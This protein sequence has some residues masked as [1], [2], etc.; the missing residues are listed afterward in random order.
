MLVE[1]VELEFQQKISQLTIGCPYNEI[2][3]D[4]VKLLFRTGFTSVSSC[5]DSRE[6]LIFREIFPFMIV[7]DEPNIVFGSTEKDLTV[8]FG[9]TIRVFTPDHLNRLFAPVAAALIFFSVIKGKSS[10]V[11]IKNIRLPVSLEHL[12]SKAKVLVVGAGGLGSPAIEFLLREGLKSLV[13]IEPDVV[14]ISN[15]HRQTFYSSK[16]I[17][18][19]KAEVLKKILGKRDNLDLKIYRKAFDPDTLKNEQP[20]V[21]IACVDNYKTR[22]QINEICYKEGIPFVDAGVEGLS[23]YVVP[24]RPIDACYRCFVGDDRKDRDVSKPILPFVSYFGGMLQAAYATHILKYPDEPLK[25]LWFDLKTLTFIEFQVDK[26]LNCPV[27]SS[28]E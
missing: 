20:D 16:D 23:G 2:D 11:S 5:F 13:V 1:G 14:S 28:S 15:I 27:C 26:R 8:E 19:P 7:K 10:S 18:V 17:G 4:I 3:R 25:A 6:I 24:H 22:Y 9:E 21:V 12:P